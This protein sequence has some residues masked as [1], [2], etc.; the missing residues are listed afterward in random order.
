MKSHGVANFNNFFIE[1]RKKDSNKCQFKNADS[2]SR[3][4]KGEGEKEVDLNE[5]T[6]NVAKVRLY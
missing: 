3:H 6:E 2:L 4:G 5:N 1:V